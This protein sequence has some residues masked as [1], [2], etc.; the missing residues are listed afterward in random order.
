MIYEPELDDARLVETWRLGRR[1]IVMLFTNI[2]TLGS[3]EYAFA[4]VV[5]DQDTQETCLFVASEVNP[6]ATW[7]GQG[8]HLL[9]AMDDR[10]YENFGNSDAWADVQT[11]AWIGLFIVARRLRAT[12]S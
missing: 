7:P 12:L 1:Y 3:I 11:F 8:S 10:Q 5:I 4:L 2:E 9:T 6:L